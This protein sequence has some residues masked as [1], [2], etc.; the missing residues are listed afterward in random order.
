[1]LSFALVALWDD[2]LRG[3]HRFL[4]LGGVILALGASLA[5]GLAHLRASGHS[6]AG[7]AL[8]PTAR[9]LLGYARAITLAAILGACIYYILQFV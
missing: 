3:S 5:V 7:D 9:G 2:P 8:D 1:M 6:R 4:V